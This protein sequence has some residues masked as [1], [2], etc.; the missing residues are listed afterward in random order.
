MVRAASEP[1]RP[2]D[3][4]VSYIPTGYGYQATAIA[5]VWAEGD[6]AKCRLCPLGECVARGGTAYLV[7]VNAFVPASETVMFRKPKGGDR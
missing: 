4:Q 1:P 6:S 2:I 7:T 3:C 5:R